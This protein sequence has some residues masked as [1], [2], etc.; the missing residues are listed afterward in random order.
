MFIYTFAWQLNVCFNYKVINNKL[1]MLF[2]NK[3]RLFNCKIS[4]QCSIPNGDL[5]YKNYFNNVKILTYDF[6]LQKITFFNNTGAE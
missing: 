4:A 1:S 2:F 6:Q 5:G 3:Y